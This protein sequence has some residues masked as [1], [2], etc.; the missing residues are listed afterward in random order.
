MATIF[1]I[2]NW[3]MLGLSVALLGIEV[4][5]LVN[6]LRFRPDAY[7]AAGKRTKP[8]WAAMTLGAVVIGLLSLLNML[9]LFFAIIGIVMAG[10]FLADVLPAL[11]TVMGNAQGSYGRRNPGRG[12]SGRGPRRR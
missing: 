2:E 1:L 5:A 6:A 4:W 12:G 11:R 7:T 3:I 9:G 8:F 10:V